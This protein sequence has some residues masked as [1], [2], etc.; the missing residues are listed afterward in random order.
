MANRYTINRLV[1]SLEQKGFTYET[2]YN[3]IGDA[4]SRI[5]GDRKANRG[6]ILTMQEANARLTAKYKEKAILFTNKTYQEEV[7]SLIKSLEFTTQKSFLKGKK[8]EMIQIIDDYLEDIGRETEVDYSKLDAETLNNIFK[9][10]KQRH[11]EKEA[12]SS[13]KQGLFKEILIDTIEEN[14]R[15][16]IDFASV[17]E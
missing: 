17:L 16:K 12:E 15:E 2:K 1:K 10:A 6:M 14:D 3:R 9:L 4:Y 11:N 7:N 8:E 5:I 13:G